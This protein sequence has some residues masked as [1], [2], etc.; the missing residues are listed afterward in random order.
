M[1]MNEDYGSAEEQAERMLERT[2][3]A[4]SPMTRSDRDRGGER[5]QEEPA[6][7][8]LH[9]GRQLLARP[10]SKL[11]AGIAL[12][13]GSTAMLVARDARAYR[14]LRSLGRRSRAAVMTFFEPRRGTGS[15]GIAALTGLAALALA[16]AT[17]KR[18]DAIERP[19]SE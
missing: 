7:R 9:T 15:L 10:E 4:S 6:Q 17:W 11:I 12:V 14:G 16:G 3:Q 2:T 8:L 13:A 5:D 18:I 19:R 1:S